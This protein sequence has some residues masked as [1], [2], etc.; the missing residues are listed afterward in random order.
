[1]ILPSTEKDQILLGENAFQSAKLEER[2]AAKRFDPSRCLVKSKLR[3][4]YDGVFVFVCVCV[5][6]KL[7]D[8]TKDKEVVSGFIISEKCW[9]FSN[10]K[11]H[12]LGEWRHLVNYQE[13]DTSLGLKLNLALRAFLQENGGIWEITR[14][15]ISIQD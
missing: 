15:W 1:M 3:W 8:F 5:S 6:H 9:F 4:I 7:I 14:N 12:S 2:F 11:I 13:L 10:I